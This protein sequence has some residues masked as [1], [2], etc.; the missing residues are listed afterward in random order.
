[1][2]AKESTQHASDLGLYPR[3]AHH[4]WRDRNIQVPGVFCDVDDES[5]IT[6]GGMSETMVVSQV[7]A[8]PNQSR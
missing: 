3:V 6:P 7:T 4:P 2:V 8:H 5:L 1:M